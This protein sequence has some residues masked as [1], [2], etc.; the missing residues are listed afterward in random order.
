MT[1]DDEIEEANKQ[2]WQNASEQYRMREEDPP[3]TLYHY[4]DAAGLEGILR[5]GTIWATHAGYL[6]D[7]H[8]VVHGQEIFRSMITRTLIHSKDVIGREFYDKCI[9][10]FDEKGPFM[11]PLVG[12][13]CASFSSKGDDLS[14]Y[15]AYSAQGSGY[16]IGFDTKALVAEIGKISY[17]NGSLFRLVRMEYD[18][19]EQ[20]RTLERIVRD[21][22]SL[23]RTLAREHGD[24]ARETVLHKLS[25]QCIQEALMVG[26][27]YK[28][29]GFQD[30]DEWRIVP[31]PFGDPAK[32]FDTN[33]RARHRNG[34]FIPYLEL[35]V[36]P[37]DR[38]T[39]SVREIYV[40]PKLPFDKARNGIVKLF[41]TL[42]VSNNLDFEEAKIKRSSTFLQ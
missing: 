28:Q 32:P 37:S 18:T 15:R 27:L 34:L 9:E 38:R 8:E 29:P 41:H 19:A 7:P 36:D 25:L 13:F 39:T 1:L 22:V 24:Q 4:T 11:N 26:C 3:T 17:A 35:P 6:N 31:T 23:A 21:A 42:K 2:S 5:S 10:N 16:C 30:E 12:Y 14:Q 20:R 33:V 40:G